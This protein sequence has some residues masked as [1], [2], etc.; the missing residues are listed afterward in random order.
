MA[1]INFISQNQVAILAAVTSIGWG[2]C[3]ILAYSPGVKA[4][5]TFQ[6]IFGFFKKEAGK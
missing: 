5:S 3:E 2:V 1:F 6:A 4:N